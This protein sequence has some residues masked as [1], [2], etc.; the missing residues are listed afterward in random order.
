[1]SCSAI[2]RSH[3]KS[4]TSRALKTA[5]IWCESKDDHFDSIDTLSRRSSDRNAPISIF[6]SEYSSFEQITKA[7]IVLS[8]IQRK[9]SS[10]N[11]KAIISLWERV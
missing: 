4:L 11:L 3:P 5:S 1:M 7:K 8:S 6:G 10:L 9:L 2:L